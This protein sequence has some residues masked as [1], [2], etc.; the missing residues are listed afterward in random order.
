[1]TKITR[2]ISNPPYDWLAL[3]GAAVQVF[4]FYAPEGKAIAEPIAYSLRVP[5]GDVRYHVSHVRRN[6][7]Q[8]APG[9]LQCQTM[10]VSVMTSS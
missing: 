8:Q 4:L 2:L 1:V 5:L 10:T 9:T 6:H 3:E 7:Y